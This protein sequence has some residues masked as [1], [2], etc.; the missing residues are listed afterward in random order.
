MRIMVLLRPRA[1]G[2]AF[3][4]KRLMKIRMTS[5]AVSLSSLAVIAAVA[6]TATAEVQTGPRLKCSTEIFDFGYVPQG[7]TVS[8]TYWLRNTGTETAIIKQL[9]PNCGCT[10]VPPTDS[11]IAVGDS[12]PVEILFG[13]R[14]ISGKV[15][16][17]TRIVSNAEGRVPALT[18]RSRVFKAGENPAPVVAEPAIV[19][20]GGANEA[21]FTLKNLGKSAIS[22]Q[23]VDSPPGFIKLS[24]NELSLAPDESKEVRFEIIPQ[25]GKSDYTKSITLE[26]NDSAKSRITIPIT[27]IQKE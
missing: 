3:V 14:N 11:T 18:F 9:K 24:F 22:A 7:A 5:V 1:S 12:L 20:T 13:S 8:H 25:K 16:K 15:E 23:L 21:S 19:Q 17:F 26:L 4:L 2:Q 6:C 10:E 27:N